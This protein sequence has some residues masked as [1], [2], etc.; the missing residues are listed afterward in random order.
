MLVLSCAASP[1]SNSI[2]DL[3]GEDEDLAKAV[4][5]SLETPSA[6]APPAYG[7]DSLEWKQKHWA[8]TAP[9]TD[10][11]AAAC[12]RRRHHSVAGSCRLQ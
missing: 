8:V 5:A 6:Q 11:S 4:K 10:V 2:I 1:K 9:R 3:T 12:R 7:I